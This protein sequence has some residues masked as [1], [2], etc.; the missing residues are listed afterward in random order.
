M[1]DKTSRPSGALGQS[2]GPATDR[3]NNPVVDPTSNV[4]D[5]VDSAVRRIDDLQRVNN[6]R[7]DERMGDEK[8]HIR[9]LMMMTA[10]YEEK[11]R[12]AESNR[13]D[14]IRA[15]DVAAVGVASERQTQAAGVLATNLTGNAETLRTL[16]ATTAAATS[17]QLTQII[18]PILDRLSLIEKSQYE[19]KGKEGVTDPLMSQLVAEMRATRETIALGAGAKQGESDNRSNTRLDIGSVVGL[20]GMVIGVVSIL[21]VLTSR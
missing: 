7:I 11:L 10:D 21:I 19:G 5:L 4:L 1:T 8:T 14:A 16:V 2:Q 20:V 3:S 6:Q 17:A 18:T 12:V 15:V 9:E 13:I